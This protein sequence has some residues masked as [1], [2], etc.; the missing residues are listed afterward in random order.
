M[1]KYNKSNKRYTLPIMMYG[2]K[3]NDPL[4]YSYMNFPNPTILENSGLGTTIVPYVDGTALDKDGLYGPKTEEQYKFYGQLYNEETGKSLNRQFGGYSGN[5]N[6][7]ITENQQK[8][9]YIGI[10][11]EP[12]FLYKNPNNNN[13]S[14]YYQPFYPGTNDNRTY[15][16]KSGGVVNNLE[17]MLYK[18]GG[19]IQKATDSI[20]RRGTKGKC[21]PITKPGCT[22][23]A[24][25]LALTFKKIAR[26]RKNN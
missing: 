7:Y 23:R 12:Q 8:P 17:T 9:L 15:K 14:K 21:T 13:N 19:W 1:P 25:A 10:P 24:K 16:Y 5:T 2:E 4:L 20:K 26:N 22:G 18:S 6:Q 3:P 11:P